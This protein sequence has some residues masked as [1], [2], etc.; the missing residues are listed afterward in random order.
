MVQFQLGH[1]V[2]IFTIS[3]PGFFCSVF[4]LKIIRSGQSPEIL[5]TRT[6][7]Y[8][9]L[10]SGSVADAQALAYF[11]INIS[12]KNSSTAMSKKHGNSVCKRCRRSYELY[13]ASARERKETRE[14][15][16]T[17]FKDCIVFLSE[18][19]QKY[20]NLTFAQQLSEIFEWLCSSQTQMSFTHRTVLAKSKLSRP[21]FACP[22]REKNRHI[23]SRYPLDCREWPLEN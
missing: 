18:I 19:T 5:T 2:P 23:F 6:Y 13:S 22:A 11:S 16:I 3:Q 17:I 7:S 12:L 8:G 4:T 15:T 1:S 14:Q 9:S 10:P 21:F 20:Q